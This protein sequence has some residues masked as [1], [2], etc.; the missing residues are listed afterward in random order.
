MSIRIP[1]EAFLRA[2]VYAFARLAGLKE[3]S[4]P[5]KALAALVKQPFARAAPD[6]RSKPMMG[7]LREAQVLWVRRSALPKLVAESKAG[8]KTA[9]TL[10]DYGHALAKAVVRFVNSAAFRRGNHDVTSALSPEE[11]DWIDR[12]ILDASGSKYR[13]NDLSYRG[14]VVLGSQDRVFWIGVSEDTAIVNETAAAVRAAHLL[15]RTVSFPIARRYRWTEAA[16]FSRDPNALREAS[17]ALIRTMSGT[18]ALVIERSTTL[19]AEWLPKDSTFFLPGNIVIWYVSEIPSEQVATEYGRLRVL[20]RQTSRNPETV[21]AFAVDRDETFA[22]AIRQAVVDRP[23]LVVGPDTFRYAIGPYPWLWSRYLAPDH[24]VQVFE[25]AADFARRRPGPDFGIVHPRIAAADM[26]SNCQIIGVPGSGKTTAV[27]DLLERTHDQPILTLTGTKDTQL[28]RA[29]VEQTCPGGATIIIENLQDQATTAL[30]G[31]P[32]YQL[33]D[34]PNIRWVVTYD[35]PD[36]IQVRRHCPQLDFVPI[37]DLDD[38]ATLKPL[39]SALGS[40]YAITADDG[41]FAFLAT[42]VEA[43]D[44]AARTLVEYLTRFKKQT[45]D[46]KKPLPTQSLPYWHGRAARVNGVPR[47]LMYVVVSLWLLGADPLGMRLLRRVAK[48]RGILGV[49][50][51]MHELVEG[52]WL[53]TDNHR[54]AIAVREACAQAWDVGADVRR[55]GEIIATCLTIIDEIGTEERRQLLRGIYEWQTASQGSEEPIP[56]NPRETFRL[57]H[58]EPPI[59]EE[60]NV[61]AIDLARIGEFEQAA[62]ILTAYT[63][64]RSEDEDAVRQAWMDLFR[65]AEEVPLKKPTL[66][67]AQRALTVVGNAG[68]LMGEVLTL[69]VDNGALRRGAELLTWGT[70]QGIV[71]RAEI[72]ELLLNPRP[73]A[74]EALRKRFVEMHKQLQY[75]LPS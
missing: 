51:A 9:E 60:M 63:I 29:I 14:V 11:R 45:L 42:R 61:Y 26:S 49:D 38:G 17:R 58:P 21:V 4:I 73:E 52:R 6:A 35:S 13:V 53:H 65:I 64:Q 43:W 37:V 40:H 7:W 39:A 72:D 71:S 55:L 50:A 68:R 36:A 47:D 19:D 48:E 59:A 31:T 70:S 8:E 67:L 44:G 10:F 5:A 15:R 56:G 24:E 16:E 1:S 12:E 2:Y 32:L 46:W 62:D 54:E 23:V 28:A 22:A 30:V 27:H 34:I 75:L 69:L 33:K 41:D 3:S 74:D 18:T 25:N 66:P 57:L 20:L